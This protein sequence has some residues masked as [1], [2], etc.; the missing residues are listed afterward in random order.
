M[1]G[2]GGGNWSDN[3]GDGGGTGIVDIAVQ[4]GQ[5]LYIS[6]GGS[7]TNNH[8]G[9]WTQWFQYNGSNGWNVNGDQKWPG[10][11]NG[12]GAGG[13]WGSDGY[14]TPK[15]GA[16]GG[17]ATQIQSQLVGGGQLQEYAYYRDR[18]IAVVGGGAGGS[19]AAE[20]DARLPTGGAPGS[21]N[22]V[23]NGEIAAGQNRRP[24]CVW[25][26]YNHTVTSG[27][28][29]FSR[30]IQG[31]FGKGADAGGSGPCSGAQP[32]GHRWQ[33][34]AKDHLLRPGGRRPAQDR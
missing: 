31:S 24:Y 16:S 9:N 7:G 2:G 27:E 25:D 30:E 14:T 20:G 4:K 28:G 34:P 5:T 10:G 29:G 19:G 18:V 22:S 6:V 17:G 8:G 12:G 13:K 33:P 32:A 11:W 3:Y 23:Q 1:A 15:W 21:L 26:W